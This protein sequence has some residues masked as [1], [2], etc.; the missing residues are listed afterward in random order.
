MKTFEEKFTA[1]LDGALS[2][3]ESLAF[4]KEH[5][6]IL[7]EGRDLLKLRSLL[8]DNLERAELPHP[9]FFNAQ[10]MAQVEREANRRRIGRRSWLGLPRLAWGGIA[11]LAAGLALFVVL[12]PHGDLSNPRTGYVAEVLKAKTVD[13]KVKATVDSQKDMTI[14][15]LEGLRNLPADKDLKR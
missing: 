14:I 13:P 10:I 8:K 6:S 12:I 2:K 15:K 3:D 5:P 9:E 7:D 1:W 4:E 11:S